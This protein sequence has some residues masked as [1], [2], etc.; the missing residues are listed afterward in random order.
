MAPRKGAEPLCICGEEIGNSG[1]ASFITVSDKGL[2][3]S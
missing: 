1:R 3:D 2:P